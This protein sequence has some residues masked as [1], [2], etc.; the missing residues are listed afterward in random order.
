ML[1]RFLTMDGNPDA[2][3]KIR[4]K[5]INKISRLLINLGKQS[6]MDDRQMANASIIQCLNTRQRMWINTLQESKSKWPVNMKKCCFFSVKT[7]TYYSKPIRLLGNREWSIFFSQ[8]TGKRILLT[9]SWRKSEIFY[10]FW[11]AFGNIC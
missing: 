10:L 9:H 11:K 7:I 2:I 6:Y 4:I 1:K 3:K 5:H 8:V